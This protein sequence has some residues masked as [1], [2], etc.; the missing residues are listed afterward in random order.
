MRGAN[1]CYACWNLICLYVSRVT[2]ECCC[3]CCRKRFDFASYVRCLADNEWDDVDVDGDDDEEDRDTEDSEEMDVD[4]VK[5]RKPGR[6]YRNQVILPHTCV[7]L[8]CCY[9]HRHHHD[10]A[11]S[12][13][14]AV[15]TKCF[16]CSRS[17][18]YF[19]AELRPRFSG[20]SLLP[21]CI[22]R[23]DE[24]I[25]VDASNLC[26][27]DQRCIVCLFQCAIGLMARDFT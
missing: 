24:D 15:S 14:I 12:W 22:A 21:G 6:Y 11:P 4:K 20:R 19:H 10:H 13:S 3:I 17:W 16:Q 8:L 23:Y 25:Q 1:G 18:V 7:W 2:N 26:C 9:H 5:L 27:Y